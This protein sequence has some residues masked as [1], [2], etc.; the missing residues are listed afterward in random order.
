MSEFRLIRLKPGIALVDKY[1]LPIQ[2]FARG[3][4]AVVQQIEAHEEEIE[5]AQAAITV[6]EAATPNYVLRLQTTAWD[7]PTGTLDRTTFAAYAGQ[8][9]SATPT[10]AQVQAIDNHTTVLSQR[11]AALIT[12]LRANGVLT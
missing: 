7:D 4:Q 5:A 3:W 12:D 11:L 10:Q 1:G 2:F 9:V 6:L 8:T